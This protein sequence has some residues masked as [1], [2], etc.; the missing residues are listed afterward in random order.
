MAGEEGPGGHED[1]RLLEAFVLREVERWKILAL[2]GTLVE[3]V[4]SMASCH[5]KVQ[6]R[7]E[8][9]RSPYPVHPVLLDNWEQAT[10][11]QTSA[12]LVAPWQ[13]V[14]VEV[15]GEACQTQLD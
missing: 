5:E 4:P 1:C 7:D 14:Q 11:H 8:S 15:S 2:Q 9:V 6:G 12:G 13:G 10:V 3:F